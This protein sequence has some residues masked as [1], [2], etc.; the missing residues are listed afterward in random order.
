M[1]AVLALFGGLF[2]IE[3]SEF[4]KTSYAQ[5]SE[6]YNWEYVGKN[7]RQVFIPA[8]PIIIEETNEEIIYYKLKK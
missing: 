6:G 4:F 3:N 5:R 2:Y 1:L 8:L 7:K